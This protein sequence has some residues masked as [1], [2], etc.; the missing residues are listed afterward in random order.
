MTSEFAQFLQNHFTVYGDGKININ[1]ATEKA[2][3]WLGFSSELIEKMDRFRKGMDGILGNDDDGIFDNVAQIINQLG[4]TESLMP[5][6]VAQITNN[7]NSFSTFSS[8]FEIQ[9]VPILWGKVYPY[10][11]KATVERQPNGIL[12][13]ETK[14]FFMDFV[15]EGIGIPVENEDSLDFSP[16]DY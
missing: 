15:P 3:L 4:E 6:E 7:I 16:E 2:F 10:S 13:L 8:F 1:F 5:D 9:V 14:E 11:L 12:V